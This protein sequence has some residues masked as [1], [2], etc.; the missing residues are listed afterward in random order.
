[1]LMNVR[2][3]LDKEIEAFRERTVVYRGLGYD[4]FLAARIV[5]ESGGVLRGPALNVGTGKGI[6]ASELATRWGIKVVTV[7]IDD[8]DRGIAVVL[9]RLSGV[10][11]RIRFVQADAAALPFAANEFCCA[12][13]MHV[14]HELADPA[15]PVRE[16]VR[17]VRPGGVVILADFD[18]SGLDLI[19]RAHRAEGREHPD[20]GVTVKR[21]QAIAESL[22]L[23][24]GHPPAVPFHDVAVLRKPERYE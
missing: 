7:D 21:A 1:M 6:M 5:S 8:A 20:S 23:Q 19:A 14:L 13:T 4:R 16:M 11:D 2:D 3:D 18:R 24:V 12:V 9:A 15:P 22:G 10:L 17:V